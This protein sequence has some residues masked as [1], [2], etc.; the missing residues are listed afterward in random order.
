MLVAMPGFNATAPDN[1]VE[2]PFTAGNLDRYITRTSI[3]S[4][5]TSWLPQFSG[6][7]LDAGCGKMPYRAFIRS[8]SRISE[9][10]GLDIQGALNYDDVAPDYTWDGKRM[11]FEEGAFDC[12][13]ATEVLEHCP[14]PDVFLGEVHRVLRPGGKLFFT[15]PFLWNLHEVPHDE[16]RYTPFALERHLTR[17]GFQEVSIHAMG[18]WHASLAQMLGLWLR[19]SGLSEGKQ[20]VLPFLLMPVIKA[21]LAKD[22]PQAVTF[23]EGAMITGLHGSAEKGLAGRGAA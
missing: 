18:G 2:V 4:A 11:P 16:Y 20:K 13:L 9:Y 7:L 12:V 22:D 19:R 10:V 23:T 5:I 1:F 15:V 17:T 3:L 21:L 8:K 14:E 6:R